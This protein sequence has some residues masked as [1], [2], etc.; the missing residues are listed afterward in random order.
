MAHTL[1]LPPVLKNIVMDFLAPSRTRIEKHRSEFHQDILEIGR[2]RLDTF[3]VMPCIREL[4]AYLNLNLQ[5][6]VL[7]RQWETYTPA[8]YYQFPRF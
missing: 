2:I 5:P 8:N 1:P 6:P 3:E 7:V 4:V